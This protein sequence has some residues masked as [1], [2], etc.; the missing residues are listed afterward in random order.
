[1]KKL[2]EVFCWFCNETVKSSEH[3]KNFTKLH[4]KYKGKWIAIL[5]RKV[6]AN[7]KGISMLYEK[8]T[9]FKKTPLVL[10]MWESPTRC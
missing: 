4:I 9:P 7:D 1:M 6:I 5:G 8:I 10:F 2:N 3:E